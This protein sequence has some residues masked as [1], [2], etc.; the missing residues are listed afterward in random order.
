MVLL[1]Y[2]KT[3]KRSLFVVVVVVDYGNQCRQKQF[4]RI[5]N[6]CIWSRSQS[7][8]T[9]FPWC[10]RFIY[11]SMLDYVETQE[12]QNKRMEFYK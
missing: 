4:I 11:A 2:I 8:H 7:Q 1:A 10:I 3:A 5:A 9:P 6:L 12:T